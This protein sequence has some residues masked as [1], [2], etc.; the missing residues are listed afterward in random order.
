MEKRDAIGK[1]IQE[2][3]KEPRADKNLAISSEPVGFSEKGGDV[4]RR[5]VRCKPVGFSE[6]GGGGM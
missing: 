1:E 3:I 2:K 6:K 4:D 5:D